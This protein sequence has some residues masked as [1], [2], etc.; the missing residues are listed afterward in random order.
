LNVWQAALSETLAAVEVVSR[1]KGFALGLGG[2]TLRFNRI[3]CDYRP[4]GRSFRMFSRMI[5][6]SI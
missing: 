1:I 3:A 2:M 6:K 4:N 5:A